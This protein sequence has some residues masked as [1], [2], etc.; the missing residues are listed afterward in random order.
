MCAYSYNL[1]HESKNQMLFASMQV[2]GPDVDNIAA[3]G[4]C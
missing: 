4:L 3:N 1:P 2:L